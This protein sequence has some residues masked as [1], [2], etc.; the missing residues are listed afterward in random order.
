MYSTL[1]KYTEEK[2]NIQA[3]LTLELGHQK[4]SWS[5]PIIWHLP[6]IENREPTSQQ[7]QLNLIY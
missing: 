4:E 2:E 3:K 6:S 1:S 5:K 7:L